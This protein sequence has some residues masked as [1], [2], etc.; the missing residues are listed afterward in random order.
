MKTTCFMGFWTALAIL[1]CGSAV[2]A[3]DTISTFTAPTL[4]GGSLSGENPFS[5]TLLPAP[6]VQIAGGYYETAV[7]FPAYQEGKKDYNANIYET[8]PFILRMTL[9][10]GWSIREPAD[11]TP[12]MFAFTPMDIYNGTERAGMVGFNVFELMEGVPEDR[13]YR[14]VYHQLMLGSMVNWD[15]GYT[16]VTGTKTA[17]TATCQ[18][19]SK[20][21]GPEWAGRM[22]DAPVRLSPAI[23]SYDKN[24]RVYIAM[25]F[26]EGSLT[27][28]Q[29]QTIARS[30]R[31]ERE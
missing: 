17:C 25:P 13:F 4:N 10:D 7:A 9:P 22:P 26:Q 31:L 23:L 21:G 24:L 16:P 5:G 28:E 2:Q 14:M 8:A 19:M 30:I 18:V 1:L 6:S 12:S 27:D 20:D 3:Q 29:L 15:N 11:K